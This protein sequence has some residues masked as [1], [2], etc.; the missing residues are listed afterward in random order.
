MLA[1]WCVGSGHRVVMVHGFTQTHETWQELSDDLK[2]EFDA[3]IKWNALEKY[4]F[5][6]SAFSLTGFVLDDE[7]E[8]VV[9]AECASPIL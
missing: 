1:N 6:S 5:Y 4:Y 2:D 3:P 7:A 8:W 9:C